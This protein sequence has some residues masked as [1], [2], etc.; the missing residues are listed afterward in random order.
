LPSGSGGD[1]PTPPPTDAAP[2]TE[3]STT[4]SSLTSKT[5]PAQPTALAITTTEASKS[6][7]SSAID[8]SAYKGYFDVFDCD[9]NQSFIC[10]VNLTMQK[11]QAIVKKLNFTA[12]AKEMRTPKQKQQ[13]C[14]AAFKITQSIFSIST[15]YIFLIYL[16]VQR[17]STRCSP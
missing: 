9:K 6:D 15:N 3:A 16:C 5:D 13:D 8:E 1:V 2:Q 7:K 14:M 17:K 12:Q 4:T 11:N 10:V